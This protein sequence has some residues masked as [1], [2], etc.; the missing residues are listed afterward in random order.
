MKH[1]RLSA[2]LP[3][4]LA[5]LGGG[6]ALAQTGVL[7]K[8]WTLQRPPL[9]A[10]NLRSI[11]A[12]GTSSLVAVGG[13]GT[14]L[15][16][17]NV[18]TGWSKNTVPGNLAAD[19][20]DVTYADSSAGSKYVV[21]GSAS[22]ILTAPD[23]LGT[24]PT[25]LTWTAVTSSKFVST[26]QFNAVAINGSTWVAAG[27]TA[28]GTG[29]VVVSRDQG[30]TWLRYGV[31]S[32]TALLDVT[33]IPTNAGTYIYAVMN[34]YLVYSFNYGV[35]WS[36]VFLGTGVTVKSIAYATPSGLNPVINITGSTS[37]T[38][39]GAG[40]LSATNSAPA[41]VAITWTG[42]DLVGVTR[43]GQ[44]WHSSDGGQDWQNI[45]NT[46]TSTVP[47]TPFNR[48]INIGDKLFVAVG[49]GGIIQSFALTDTGGAWTS[50]TTAGITSFPA[51]SI[52]WN[53][54]T[55][56]NSRY[57]AV[58]S[59]ITWTSQD[60]VTW[61]QNPQTTST[62]NMLQVMWSGSYFV[63]VGNGLWVSADGV[64]WQSQVAAPV[65]GTAPSVY[66]VNRLGGTPVALGFGPLPSNS[67]VSAVMLSFGDSLGYAWSAFKPITTAQWA[68]LGITKSDAGLYVAVGWGGRVLVSKTPSN[69]AS[70]TQYIVSL[71]SGEDFTDVLWANNMFVAVTSKGGI[72]TSANGSTWV[73]RKAASQAL[74]CITRVKHATTSGYDDQFIA[75]GDH[76]LLVT[77]FNGEE[78]AEA[79]MGTSQFTNQ[80]LWRPS[81][82]IDTITHT[83]S[84]TDTVKTTTYTVDTGTQTLNSNIETKVS[85]FLVT[86]VEQVLTISTNPLVR[87]VLSTSSTNGTAD[88]TTS[89]VAGTPVSP[90]TTSAPATVVSATQSTVTKDFDYTQGSSGAGVT[91]TSAQ[92][93]ST[94]YGLLSAG[95]YGA[96][97]SSNGTPPVQ[98]KV[99]F[100][101][102]ASSIPAWGGS[103]VVTVNLSA[104]NAL[105][106]TVT[107][108]FTGTAALTDYKRSATSV[109]FAAG[110]T[111]KTLTITG[112]NDS[113]AHHDA[114]AIITMTKA[115]GDVKIG[116][117][118]VHTVTITDTVQAVTTTDSFVTV[119]SPVT[120]SSTIA[121]PPSGTLVYQWYKNNKAISGATGAYFLIPAATLA[122]A[123]AYTVTARSSTSGTG[124]SNTVQVGV[125]DGS[126]Q[127]VTGKTAGSSITYPVISVKV[128]GTGL[129][130]QWKRNGSLLNGATSGSLAL[131]SSNAAS[132][133]A[134]TCDVT[135]GGDTLTSGN[136]VFLTVTTQAGAGKPTF[137]NGQVGQVYPV[138]TIASSNNASNWTITGL[139]PGLTYNSTRGT[140]SG[141][142]TKAGTYAV[143]VQASNA[144]GTLN[145]TAVV[146]SLTVTPLQAGAVGTYMG[147]VGSNAAANL[148]LGGR[149]DLATTA[150]GSFTG[151]L[152]DATGVHPF[153]GVLGGSD[154]IVRT[155]SVLLPAQTLT[156]TLNGGSGAF[157]GSVAAGGDTASMAGWRKTAQTV[158]RSGRYSMAI[159]PASSTNG[160]GYA[161]FVVDAAGNLTFTG[162]V[163]DETATAY[164]ASCFMGPNGEYGFFQPLYGG[165]GSLQGRMQV[166]QGV[167]PQHEDNFL[168]GSLNLARIVSPATTANPAVYTV[169]G[170]RY[171]APAKGKI[172]MNLLPVGNNLSV[173]FTGADIAGGAQSPDG[174]FTL[175]PPATV[176]PPSP[177]DTETGLE[178]KTA[179]GEFD[180]LFKLTDAGVER[181]A[182]FFGV[183]IRPAGSATMIGK[184][185]FDITARAPA[186]GTLVG[187]VNLVKNP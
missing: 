157:A 31:S 124:Q 94:P 116:T 111:T 3:L 91:P 86:R 131:S 174:L 171:V 95:G 151:K 12:N 6:T 97:F 68:M 2:L 19:L 29:V 60:G 147:V 40:A 173:A 98:V 49:D 158:V 163:A 51:N 107:F 44:L 39:V 159:N 137:P 175:L 185:F 113:L 37:F 66:T 168:T 48:A 71:A 149:V 50:L 139:P 63:A 22:T 79:D 25:G 89:N 20:W 70:W 1:S 58:G 172:V 8:D 67:K 144:F 4:V 155:G 102:A 38:A 53:E 77:S 69:T 126:D 187:A 57:V 90:W 106:V 74:W 142:P 81:T 118:A 85:K 152:T 72:W 56:S 108:S 5:L 55:D 109:T 184:G 127:L 17:P 129:T 64:T 35:T 138:F 165:A 34:G 180:G 103:Q 23:T 11:A 15:T 122:D 52:A 166:A 177:N 46:A 10:E 33:T 125:L 41:N 43:T 145:T 112:V 104:A 135:M 181:T 96:F 27:A 80:I 42:T 61:T 115:T 54:K 65:T 114:T 164:T 92:N 26:D 73:K 123:A 146:S 133:D 140:I 47:G 134:F 83:D 132:G 136:I 62:M 14:I 24:T 110:E 179:T 167:S 183:A 7:G 117:T 130:Y 182:L 162:R 76:G 105:P 169:D 120:L 32:S 150:L 9:T 128:A 16:T 154:P 18:G 75:A 156:F 87:R 148:G 93:S 36:R 82:S 119:G 186:T 84:E 100:A 178:F 88:V 78:W 141:T 160:S 45:S 101:T 21:V 99:N 59:G 170:G 121:A 153:Y 13:H 176:I 143:R 30:A 28:A 161:L